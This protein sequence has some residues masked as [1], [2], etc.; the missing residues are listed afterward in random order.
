MT[1][2]LCVESPGVAPFEQAASAPELIIGRAASSG[3]VVPD[4]SVSRQHARLFQ[5]DAAW[6]LE[7]L[8]GRNGTWLNDE[9][10]SGEPV[11]VQI[12]DRLRVGGTTVRIAGPVADLATAAPTAPIRTIGRDGTDGDRQAAWLRTLNDV[13]HALATAISLPSLLDLILE[14]CFEVL[15]PEEGVIL[16]ADRDGEMRPAATRRVAGAS[17]PV[18]VSR[19]IIDEV[20]KKG[21]PTLVF[22]AAEDER[23]A[24]SQSIMAAGITTVVAAPLADAAGSLGLIALMSRAHVRPF[25]PP[26]L[27]MLVSLASAAALRVRNVAL[28]EEA[29][30]RQ[31]LERE[32]ALAHDMQM[33]M[34]PK[35]LPARPEVDLAASL[36]PARS[37]GGD[38]YD[39]VP[40]GDHLWFIVGD[41][42]GKGV[43]AALYMAVAK[44]LF[45]AAVEAKSTVGDVLA[46]MNRELARENDQLIFV[47]ALVGRLTLATG[48]VSLGDAGHNPAWRVGGDGTVRPVEAP[49]G[50]A[51]GV[52]EDVAYE[53]G[54]LTLLPGETLVLYTDGATDERNPAGEAFGLARLEKTIAAAAR[55]SATGLVASI[56]GAI[57]TY[58]A[59]APAD[60]DLTVLAVRFLASP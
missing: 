40:D 28:A 60:D 39:F 47:T 2:R 58:S 14:R 20:A 13:H 42:S 57:E 10:L 6:W 48:A 59:G 12:G 35:A 3:L 7:D 55:A 44:T 29:A 22:D 52:V 15:R 43:G 34:L 23:F 53:T 30:A 11:R 54:T 50:V 32:L 56:I 5:R 36:R 19:R 8:G 4:K 25:A 51:L 27:E 38:L 45:R 33:A 9:P 17:G 24:D 26:D 31:V 41:V 21:K 16:L 1:V 18:T 49:K 46:L 37:V